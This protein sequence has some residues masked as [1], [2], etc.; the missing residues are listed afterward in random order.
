MVWY[1]RDK[2]SGKSATFFRIQKL[3]AC[4]IKVQLEGNVGSNRWYDL[5]KEGLS[6]EQQGEINFCFDQ[7]LENFLRRISVKKN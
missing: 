5:E 2:V 3:V 4:R 6:E 1:I 7:R